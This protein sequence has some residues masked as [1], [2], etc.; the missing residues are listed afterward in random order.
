M[1]SLLVLGT[2][3]IAT[4]AVVV[5]TKPAGTVYPFAPTAPDPVADTVAVAADTVFADDGWQVATLTSLSEVE[6][7]LDSL[8]V[9]HIAQREVKTLGNSTFRVRWR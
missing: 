1:I 3:A 2:V 9:R 6:D 7:L 4:A 5:V 8:E